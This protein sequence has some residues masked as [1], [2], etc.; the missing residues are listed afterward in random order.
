M[1]QFLSAK[2]IADAKK[3]AKAKAAA[4]TARRQRLTVPLQEGL[5]RFAVRIELTATAA[6]WAAIQAVFGSLAGITWGQAWE[7]LM[8]ARGGAGLLDEPQRMQINAVLGEAA[9]NNA[10]A[11]LTD[12]GLLMTPT[13]RRS[14][15]LLVVGL[16]YRLVV[17][18]G[19]DPS[20]TALPAIAA[21][22]TKTNDLLHVVHPDEKWGWA[23]EEAVLQVA[24]VQR[25][26]ENR[27]FIEG[28][29]AVV[30]LEGL[31]EQL[32]PTDPEADRRRITA[33]WHDTAAALE[34]NRLDAV[35]RQLRLWGHDALAAKLRD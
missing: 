8:A 31:V 22:A 24:A 10:P 35:R 14:V 19:S 9:G 2:Q 13:S 20:N 6:S 3:A 5:Q 30:A 28:W 17:S 23:H 32:Q 25:V 4:E 16:E 11:W 34:K 1:Q 29:A 7:I 12:T 26:N 21:L 33:R 15:G 27:Q 18:V